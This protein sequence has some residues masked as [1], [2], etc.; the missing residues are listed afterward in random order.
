MSDSSCLNDAI[1]K[2]SHRSVRIFRIIQLSFQEW[3][4]FEWF[5][6]ISL[7]ERDNAYSKRNSLASQKL[8]F[9]G[10]GRG[11]IDA[12]ADI[13][14]CGAL[15]STGLEG[16]APATS[17]RPDH[18]PLSGRFLQRLHR[19]GKPAEL[20]ADGRQVADLLRP[21]TLPLLHELP[22]GEHLPDSG[23]AASVIGP[24]GRHN[25]GLVKNFLSRNI[26]DRVDLRRSASDQ[27]QRT[28]RYTYGHA[29]SIQPRTSVAHPAADTAAVHL[30][31]RRIQIGLNAHQ[32][33]GIEQ[34]ISKSVD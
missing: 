13:A 30:V 14:L 16:L 22:Q 3:C 21:L 34:S 18:I 26:K 23:R 32:L 4:C 8:A 11:T 24:K 25:W 5:D 31:D 20:A 28:Q 15:G 1:V 33:K 6:S 7:I 12:F 2:F 10:V 29:R 9:A 19:I 27:H 17:N